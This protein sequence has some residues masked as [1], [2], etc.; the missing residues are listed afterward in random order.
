M[1]RRM[2]IA[3]LTSTAMLLSACHDDDHDSYHSGD[4]I[5]KNNITNPVVSTPT[6]YNQTD[7]SAT[8]GES[9]VMTYK[10]LGINNKNS[11]A[12]KG[13]A[14]CSLGAW[15]DGR[16]RYLCTQSQSIK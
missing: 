3:V 11:T 9:V 2:L 6:A 16:C 4:N 15:N 14:N 1:Q 8:A 13:L 7:M 5:P 10:M 12:C